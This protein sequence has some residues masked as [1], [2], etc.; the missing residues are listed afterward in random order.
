M[1]ILPLYSEYKMNFNNVNIMHKTISN[2]FEI[3]LKNMDISI[4]MGKMMRQSLVFM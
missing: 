3:G 1:K 4:I 2:D